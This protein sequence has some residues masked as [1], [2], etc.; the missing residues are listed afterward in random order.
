MHI[1]Q[2]ILKVLR[3]YGSMKD[4]KSGS[5]AALLSDYLSKTNLTSIIN[6][7]MKTFEPEKVRQFFFIVILAVLGMILFTYLKSFLPSFLGAITFYVLMRKYMKHMLV[8]KWK[9]ASAALLLML[10]SFIMII[11]SG[12]YSCKYGQ[13]KNRICDQPCN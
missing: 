7:W 2:I 4:W 10:V 13:F 8:K 5:A 3:K 12:F 1:F 11:I 6:P 9:P